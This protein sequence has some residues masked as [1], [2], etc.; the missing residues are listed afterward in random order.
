MIAKV[1]EFSRERD[2]RNH[3]LIN[4]EFKLT[5]GWRQWL[6]ELYGKGVYRLG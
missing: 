2:I 6:L 5:R 4:F 3:C 1:I